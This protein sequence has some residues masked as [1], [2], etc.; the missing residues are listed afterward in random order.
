MKSSSSTKVT[1]RFGDRPEDAEAWLQ[2][3]TVLHVMV[4]FRSPQTPPDQWHRIMTVTN[5]WLRKHAQDTKLGAIWPALL[6]VADGSRTEIEADITRRLQDEWP[7]LVR[8]AGLLPV[9]Y[10]P[11]DV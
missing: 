1:W 8:Y 9:G 2:H 4:D 5:A 3:P 7:L 6:I 10:E 11:A